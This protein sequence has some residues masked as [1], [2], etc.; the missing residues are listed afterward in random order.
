MY[1]LSNLASREQANQIAETAPDSIEVK[2][3]V[4]MVS[5]AI[6]E[7][8]ITVA[9]QPIV[10]SSNPNIPA[11]QECLVR[12]RERN[13]EIVPAARFISAIEDSDLGRIVDRIVLRKVMKIMKETRRI[14]FSVNMSACG[15]G[16]TEWL[17]ILQEACE[18]AP[19]CG[20]L[21]VIEITE[22]SMLN[23]SDD[24]IAYLDEIR[25]LGCSIAIDDFGSGHTSIGHLGKFRFDFLKIDGSYIRDFTKNPDNQFLVKSMLSI[26]R[27]FEMVSVAEMVDNQQTA[28]ALAKLGV[29]CLQG[30]HCGKPI[31][32]PDWL[33]AA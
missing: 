26:A 24:C 23:L 4:R 31:V 17:K 33:P 13:G 18:E 30:Y 3:I 5:S 12:I 19:N 27:H 11:F 25:G 9:F 10:S 21:L 7:D 8:R 6:A 1:R 20:E 16:D 2:E 15:I 32:D 29:D 22:S 28:D 14:R